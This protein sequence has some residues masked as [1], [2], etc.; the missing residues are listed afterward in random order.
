[1]WWVLASTPVTAQSATPPFLLP[2]GVAYDA[3]GNLFVADAHRNQVLEVALDETVTV[4]AGTG[5]QGF[6]GDDGP[7]LQALL[8]APESVAVAADGT[9]YIA[10]TGNQ[11]IRAV[12]A[13]Q[14]QTVAG[15]GV[16][17]FSGDGGDA[18][19]A[20]L[21]MPLALAV[22]GRNVVIAD[23]G[24]HRVRGL[25]SGVLTTIAGSGTQGFSGDGGAAKL[26]QLDTPAGI[27]IDAN[28]RIF[29][30]DSHNHRVRM[31][32]SN[33]IITT[34]AGSG[35]RGFSG[36]GGPATRATLFLPRG[37]AVLPSGDVVFSDSDNQRLRLVN[38]LGVISTVAGNGVQGYS[39]DGAVA[40]SALLNSPRGVAISRYS[41]P[42]FADARNHL[43]QEIAANANL[44]A[45][46][47]VS[48]QVD[49]VALS[50]PAP[51]IY[52]Q[53]TVDAVV[54]TNGPAPQG[55]VVLLD[56]TSVVTAAPLVSGTAML[57]ADGLSA[58]AHVLTATFAGDG[59]HK[60]ASSSPVSTT[61]APAMVTTTATE[62]TM[63]YG[64]ITVPLSGTIAGVLARDAANVSVTFSS[65]AQDLA[66]V[67]TYP[68]GASLSGSA[69]SNYV[70]SPASSSGTLHIVQAPALINAAVPSVAYAGLP[71]TVSA[72][73]VPVTRGVPTGSVTFLD[74]GVSIVAGSVS[75]GNAAAVYLAPV[76]GTHVITALYG[77]D[78]NFLAST[79]AAA[80]LTVSAMPD[81]D[82]AVSGSPTQAVP[83]G[84]I[85]SYALIV[86]SQPAP[87][88]G[89]V[90]M[91]VTGLPSGANATFSPATVVPGSGAVP[92]SLAIQ[93]TALAMQTRPTD[94]RI[95]VLLIFGIS[96]PYVRRRT[97][98]VRGIKTLALLVGLAGL[99]AAVGCG[100]RAFT[101]S[102]RASQTLPLTITG[103]GT[104]LAGMVVTHRVTV[105]LVIE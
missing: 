67:G 44:Y 41:L 68:I 78:H 74:N 72:T 62:V 32:D 65:T 63:T 60:A 8:N 93:T 104:N 81:F 20:R 37:V 103:T 47:G 53:G 92:V 2:S 95:G 5:L 42:V 79:S 15:T 84:T 73:V 30:A 38:Q 88:S 21:N 33:G 69:S 45:L 66:P 58:G 96:L 89:A 25:S 18:R 31:I 36:D 23:S 11:R 9:L 56:G 39:P 77:G 27:A 29:F 12:V 34:I 16:K 6:A 52:G 70:V 7:A 100:D 49:S 1:M 35:A 76:A 75:G 57:T 24:N 85:A 59:V 10:D 22:Y 3:A 14:I 26:A 80:I 43:V 102:T 101:S 61:V 54:T 51:L 83:G 94:I 4:V 82:V 90:S 17:G 97:K 28:G 50:V 86:S 91:S 55:N 64:G 87:F 40:T 99:T 13:G 105:T 71:A 98:G 48:L 19:L 46:P